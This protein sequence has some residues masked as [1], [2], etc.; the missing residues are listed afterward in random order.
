MFSREALELIQSTARQAGGI[1]Q[2]ENAYTP[3]LAVPDG[4]GGIDLVSIEHLQEGRSRFRGKFQTQRLAEFVAYTDARSSDGTSGEVG[5]HP[6]SVFVD[7]DSGTAEAFFN[8]GSPTSPGH[9]DDRAALNL[10]RTAAMSALLAINGQQLTQRKLA[11]WLEDW[12]DVVSPIYSD[13]EN[14]RTL[15]NAI[16]AIRDITIASKSEAN[17][18]QEDLR[19]SRSAMEEVEARSRVVLP[20]GFF[21]VAAPFDGFT[22]RTWQLRLAVLPQEKPVL[23]VRIVGK[24][25]VDEQIAAEFEGHIRDGLAS[26]AV[27]LGTFRP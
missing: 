3:T 21:F 15:A 1:A 13:G 10:R 11:E 12:I 7:A 9:A 20:S 22:E 27:Y 17:H 2:V 24:D 23:I 8:L 19:A 5:V 16:A 26:C 18:Q 6:T 4:K 25:A 14:Q